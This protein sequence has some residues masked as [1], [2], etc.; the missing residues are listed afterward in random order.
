MG[1]SQTVTRAGMAGLMCEC[2]I[3]HHEAIRY[4]DIAHGLFNTILEKT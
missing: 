4:F 3:T 2:W 1:C